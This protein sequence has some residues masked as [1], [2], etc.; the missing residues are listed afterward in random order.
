MR[1]LGLMRATKESEAGA[2]PDKDFMERMGVFMGEVMQAGVLVATDGLHPSAKGARVQVD[3]RQGHRS[4]TARSRRSKELVASY[5]LFEVK[6]N[7]RGGRCGPRASSKV[8]GEGERELRPIFEP[9]GLLSRGL[10]C[11]GGAGRVAKPLAQG[12]G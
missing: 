6:S 12:H 7:G 5:A 10:L 9:V 1:I 8:L 4:P 11:R 2:P 3:G